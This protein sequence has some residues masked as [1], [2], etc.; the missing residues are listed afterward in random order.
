MRKE[1]EKN[2]E[3]AVEWYTAAAKQGNSDAQNNLRAKGPEDNQR[4]CCLM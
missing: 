3:R 2:L 4:Q 1:K